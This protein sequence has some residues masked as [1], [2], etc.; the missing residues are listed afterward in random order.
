[1][2]YTIV[3]HFPGATREQYEAT[4]AAV[5]PADGSLPDGQVIHLAGPSEDGWVV[6]ATHE[7]RESWERFRNETLM[8]RLK[9]G[10]DG[11]FSGPPTEI[12]FEVDN[13]VGV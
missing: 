5:H 3:N 10:I 2:A 12:T 11:G 4:L 1:M 13:Q 6:V 7:S 8:P 9:E